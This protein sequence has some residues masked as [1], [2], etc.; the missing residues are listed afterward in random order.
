MTAQELSD[1]ILK[2]SSSYFLVDMRND[3]NSYYELTEEDFNKYPLCLCGK[4][5]NL[6]MDGNLQE[7]EFIIENLPDES[8]IKAGLS[9][10]NPKISYKEFVKKATFLKEINHPVACTTLTAGRPYL[11]NGFSDFSRLG[12]FL[13]KQKDLFKDYIQFLYGSQCTEQIYNLSL[14]EYYYQ[15]NRLIDLEL[16]VSQAIK[17]FDRYNESRFLFAAMYLEARIAHANGTILKSSSYIEDIKKK[18]SSIGRAEFSFNIDAG[19]TLFSLYSGNYD[20]VYRWLKSD[21]PDEKSDFNMLDLYRYMVKIRCYIVQEEHSTAIALI[22]KLRPLLEE[23]HRNMDLCELDLLLNEALWACGKKEMALDSFNRAMKIAKRRNYQ[24][25]VGDEGVAIFEILAEYSE[26]AAE[27]DFLSAVIESCR[28]MAILYPLY[29]RPRY[30]N[31]KTFTQQEVDFLYLLQ[32]GK[33]FEDIAR[34]FFL[35]VN[36]VRYH[37]KRIYGKLNSKNA[38]QAV[39]NAQLI[40]LIK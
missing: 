38:N 22:E 17:S 25:L 1:Q 18:I 6:M 28:K 30:N 36:T 10:V 33:T 29:L 31:N 9:I 37:I 39:W 24:R 23:G 14:A 8:I 26:T 5:L 34:Y 11:L 12:S 19:E 32:Q 7:A 20:V 13:K 2:F 3:R 40:G 21:V 4:V 35:S 16:I 27:S 15:T